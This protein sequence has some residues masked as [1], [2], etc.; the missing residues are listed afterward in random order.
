[1]NNP[2][3]LHTYF[4][5]SAAFRVRIGLNLKGLA[6]EPRYFHLGKGEHGLAENR[7]VNPQG[8]VPTLIDGGRPFIQSLAILEYLEETHPE[9]PLLPDDSAERA[10]VRAMAQ[11]VSADIHPLNNTRVLKYLREELDLEEAGVLAWTQTWIK[12]GFDALEEML[13]ARERPGPFCFGERPSLADCCLVP[14]VAS[15]RRFKL[16]LDD[17]PMISAIDAAC[18]TMEEFATAAPENQPDC[19]I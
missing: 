18:L 7:A 19:D 8:F 6:F 4:R 16:P 11:I 3:I 12:A 17:Y 1:M 15:A 5:S 14:Q 9:P 2:L 10:R 13:A